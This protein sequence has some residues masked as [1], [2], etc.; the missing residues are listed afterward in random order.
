MV[1][2]APWINLRDP[3]NAAYQAMVK[4]GAL[5]CVFEQLS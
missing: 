1:L 5:L 3:G 2:L 4:L